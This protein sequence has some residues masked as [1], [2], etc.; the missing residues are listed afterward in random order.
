LNQRTILINWS[1][2]MS[3]VLLWGTSFMF[4]SVSVETIDP[5]SLVFFRVVLAAIVLL[6]VMVARGHRI[7]M[8]VNAW[9]AFLLMGFMGNLFPFFL[10]SWGQLSV[11]SGTAGMIMAI[12]PLMTMLLAHYFVEGENLTRYKIVGFAMGITGVTILLGP[13]FEGGSRAMFSGIAIF[14]AATSYAVNTI[15]VRR[16]PRFT[17]LVGGTGVMIA[18][19]I[20][21]LPIWFLLAPDGISDMSL[22]SMNSMIWLGIGPTGIA[23]IILFAVIERAGP[24][25]LS[26]INY[27]I[28]VVAF[29]TGAMILSEP[30][31]WH[32]ILAL[33]IILSGIALTRFRA[34]QVAGPAQLQ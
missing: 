24:T 16:L 1:L 25:F 28:P 10:I 14:I 27:L 26:T 9:L 2:L 12:M 5:L 29:F 11:H 13:V 7:P 6:G 3:L 20:T 34:G 23:T 17:P 15:L 19:S 30:V 33:A 18:A 4:I 21:M 31:E 22:K 8:T 32:S